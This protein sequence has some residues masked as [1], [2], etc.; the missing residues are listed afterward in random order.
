MSDPTGVRPAVRRDPSDWET[1]PIPAVPSETPAPGG[2]H[3]VAALGVVLVLYGYLFG[4]GSV[5]HGPTPDLLLASREWLNFPLGLGADFGLLGVALLL[6]A[7]GFWAGSQLGERGLAWRAVIRGY[8]PYA[9]TCTISL[10]L[11]LGGAAPLTVPREVEADAGGYALNLLLIDRLTGQDA[12][13]GLGWGVAVAGCTAV[14]LA[15]TAT[16]FTRG[17][18]W[19]ALGGLAAQL[20]LVAVLSLTAAGT[21]GWYHELGLLL[22]WCVFPLLGLTVRTARAREYGWAAAPVGVGC[23]TLLVAAERG[24]PEVAG[25]WLPLT[26]TYTA[27]IVLL[28]AWAVAH[29]GRTDAARAVRWLASRAV[30]IAL[31]VCAIGYPLLGGLDNAGLP[32][33]L[34]LLLGLAATLGLAEV[35]HRLAGVLAR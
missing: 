2:Q 16:L 23:L 27:L 30:A 5:R 21:G 35:V 34:G 4:L 26:W 14:L 18:R 13:V 28:A 11:L 8:L 25:Q 32:L 15:I 33:W 24:Y 19:L 10:L 22:T 3:V 6:A 31:L 1:Q 20:A 29:G 12:L 9:L 7:G 17:G